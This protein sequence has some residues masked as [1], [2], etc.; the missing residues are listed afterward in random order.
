MK[1]INKPHCF[2]CEKI[3]KY[4]SD[5]PIREG[6]FTADNKAFRCSLHSQ[7]QCSCCKKFYHFSWLY[8]CQKEQ[9]LVCGDCNSP[10]LKPLTFW[11]TTYTYSFYCTYCR[12]ITTIYTILNTRVLTL[13]KTRMNLVQKWS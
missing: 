3:S 11:N 12:K 5:Y 8:W 13:G 7:F 10:V 1:S 6:S 9:K 4:E 2:Y